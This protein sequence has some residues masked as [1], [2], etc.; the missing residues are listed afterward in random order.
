ME[1][2]MNNDTIELEVM[3][4]TRNAYASNAYALLLKEK[5]GNRI[6]PVVVG[7]AEAQSIAMHLEHVMPPRPVTHDLFSSVMHAFRIMPEQ[8]EI[9]HFEK[10]IFYSRIYL[11]NGTESTALDCRT[12]DAV[13]I[14]LRTGMRI[15]AQREIVDKTAYV[16]TESG[17]P[18]RE[19]EQT[20]LEEMSVERLQERLQHYVETE[21]YERAAE[22]QK[23]I[24]TK[25][26]NQ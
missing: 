14:A 13:A 25:M 19:S 17:K 6:I 1:P 20:P 5:N 24:A 21:E 7:M 10:G 8:V 3:G 12:S 2:I 11:S 23:I 22:I 9:Y 18:K 4:I 26:A 16:A 15:Y